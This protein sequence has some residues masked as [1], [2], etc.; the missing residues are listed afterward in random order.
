MNS[1]L[2]L[3]GVALV[4][5][6]LVGCNEDK[7][8][9]V[10][11]APETALENVVVEGKQPQDLTVVAANGVV[12]A[13]VLESSSSSSSKTTVSVDKPKD[14]VDSAKPNVSVPNTLGKKV[15]DTASVNKTVV[16]NKSIVKEAI[17]SSKVNE[18]ELSA[19]VSA[20]SVMPSSAK[21]CMS[22]H[23]MEKKVVGPSWKDVSAKYRGNSN[24]VST[25][26]ANITKGGKFGWNMAIP[27]PPK[28]GNSKLTDP[29]IK[30]IASF[31]V[32]L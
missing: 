12:P 2:S 8:D 25:L 13:P 23:A 1:K 24:A 26:V 17:I 3:V 22:C 6:L 5:S 9:A 7:K 4:T 21:A 27:M 28:G 30:E 18:P 19:K 32:N 11:S 29:E 31:I 15:E 20:P 10:V 16:E 14:V